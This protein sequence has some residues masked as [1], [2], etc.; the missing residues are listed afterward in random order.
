MYTKW[1][2]LERNGKVNSNTIESYA[3]VSENISQS[4]CREEQ[5]LDVST[6]AFFFPTDMHDEV[7]L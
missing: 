2:H 4:F 6:V 3:K 1:K 5:V 7:N